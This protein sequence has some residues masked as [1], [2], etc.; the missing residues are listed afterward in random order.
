MTKRQLLDKCKHL[1]QEDA[2]II[3]KALDQFVLAEK[4]NIPTYTDFLDRHKIA[5]IQSLLQKENITMKLMG[6]NDDTER[7]YLCFHKENY[8]HIEDDHVIVKVVPKLNNFTRKSL[9][10]R[11]YLGSIMGLG[12]VR[13]KLGDILI[14]S[15]QNAY[16]YVKKDIGDYIHLYLH[17]VGRIDVTTDILDESN[18]SMPEQQFKSISVTVASLRLD[19]IISKAFSISRSDS[20][21]AV[22]GG[23]VSV[24]HVVT[25]NNSVILKEGDRIGI[26][27]LGKMKIAS[28]GHE[29]KKGRI[30]ITIHRFS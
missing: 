23:R 13:Q 15:E 24:N 26:R 2:K 16:V 30:H 19:A 1:N 7:C 18:I 11:D 27:R 22:K 25:E 9:S 12:L 28:I 8:S 3:S 20:L 6:G 5:I 14:D 17:T 4:R 21:T 10:H 29:T